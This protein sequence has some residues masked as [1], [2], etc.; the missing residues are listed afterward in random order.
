MTAE[1]GHAT[2]GTLYIQTV[3]AVYKHTTAEYGHT[4]PGTYSTDC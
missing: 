2:P 1:Y 3:E 4:V